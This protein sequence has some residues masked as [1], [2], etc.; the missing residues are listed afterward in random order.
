MRVVS[1]FNT[2]FSI[3]ESW[4]VLTFGPR[5][6]IV[7]GTKYEIKPSEFYDYEKVFVKI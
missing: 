4:H 1:I 3:K 2:P 5:K 7:L 6:N